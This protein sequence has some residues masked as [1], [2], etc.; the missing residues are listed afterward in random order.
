MLRRLG[1][2]ALGMLIGVA[3]YAGPP[4]TPAEN[5]H[6]C[7]ADIQAVCTADPLSTKYPCNNFSQACNICCQTFYSG[8]A[9]LLLCRNA[10]ENP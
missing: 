3:V 10:C 6:W 4:K 1:I 2:A 9:D 7:D 5:G 8:G